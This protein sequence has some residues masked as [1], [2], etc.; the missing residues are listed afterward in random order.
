V[1][2]RKLH[3]EMD[4]VSFDIAPLTALQVEQ[5]LTRQA[6]VLQRFQKL[7]A[8]GQPID[9]AVAEQQMLVCT[10]V[11]AGLNNA[12]PD[13]KIDESRLRSEADQKLID[14][15]REKIMAESGLTMVPTG[16]A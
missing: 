16:E 11:C 7:K 8:D 15:L 13:L 2:Q 4:G 5:H 1:F 12:N 3:F 6:Q 10:L 9:S 14:A